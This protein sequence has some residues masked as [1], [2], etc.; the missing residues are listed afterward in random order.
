MFQNY[1]VETKLGT[2]F[3]T[4]TEAAHLHVHNGGS[5]VNY[6]GKITLRGCDYHLSAHAFQWKDGSFRIGRED[7]PAYENRHTLFLNRVGFAKNSEAS[8]SARVKVTEVLTQAVNDWVIANS[9][10]LFAA[11]TDKLEQAVTA[12]EADVKVTEEAL[13]NAKSKLRQASEALAL[14]LTARKS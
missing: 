2:V 1:K 13:R 7:K 11:Q 6:E 12:A 5:G 9:D 4:P 10:K 3:I 8:E 14:H